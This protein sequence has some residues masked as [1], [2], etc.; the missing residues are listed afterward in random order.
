M[1]QTKAFND[2]EVRSVPKEQ[3]L[4][5]QSLNYFSLSEV[6]TVYLNF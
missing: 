5:I 3:G 4:N 6:L 1:Q 2:I